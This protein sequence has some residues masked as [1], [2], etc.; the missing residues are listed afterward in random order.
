M[1]PKHP[2][3][4]PSIHPARPLPSYFFFSPRYYSLSSSS[5][6]IPTLH[7]VRMSC[8]QTRL[9]RS[10]DGCECPFTL[11]QKKKKNTHNGPLRGR[12]VK[13]EEQNGKNNKRSKLILCCRC[14]RIQT[15]RA[16]LFVY[17]FVNS[18]GHRTNSRWEHV[19]V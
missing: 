5:F 7:E 3:I 13:G 9:T 2:S 17:Y 8:Q 6:I 19:L 12:G 1:L 14:G 4:H 10:P 16:R 11:A 18:L 15:I